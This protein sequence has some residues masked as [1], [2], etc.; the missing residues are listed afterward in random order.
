M[1]LTARRS[2]LPEFEPIE[3]QIGFLKIDAAREDL[4]RL[5]IGFVEKE[6]SVAI[7]FILQGN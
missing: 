5:I 1:V 3:L 7:T 6:T 4:F 2:C